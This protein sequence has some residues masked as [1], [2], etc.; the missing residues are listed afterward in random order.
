[1]RAK[2]Y[3]HYAEAK[4]K[5]SLFVQPRSNQQRT[6]ELCK[7]FDDSITT[8]G[9]ATSL[10]QTEYRVDIKS[11]IA[12]F[13]S[14]K[15]SQPSRSNSTPERVLSS[16]TSLYSTSDV[17]PSQKWQRSTPTY[18]LSKLSYGKTNTASKHSTVLSLS[19]NLVSP[20]KS[21]TRLS[22]SS[23]EQR[24]TIC[25][26]Q[27]DINKFAVI[28]GEYYCRLHFKITYRL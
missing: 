5:S 2:S 27:V 9:K 15:N 24:C 26:E 4:S 21:P 20:S 1:M 14:E 3:P 23:E 28:S 10:K 6:Q 8:S 7:N 19:P 12:K 25:K 16:T 13:D 11:L 18:Q 22:V 17:T